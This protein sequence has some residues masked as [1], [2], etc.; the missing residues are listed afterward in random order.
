MTPTA[1]PISTSL[2]GRQVAAVAA[3]ADAAARFAGQH[4]ADLHALDTGRLN[5][6]GEVFR[7]LLVDV[8]DHAAFVVA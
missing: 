6:A 1:S 8:D 4:R 5:G 2:A 7:D 3:D